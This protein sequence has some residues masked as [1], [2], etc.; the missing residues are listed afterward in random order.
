M[1]RSIAQALAD[2]AAALAAMQAPDGSF[3]FFTRTP[4]LPWVPCD[5]IFATASVLL[6]AAAL[7]PQE[8]VVRAAAY[9]RGRRRPDGLWQYDATLDVPPDADTTACS[10]AA[11]SEC[12]GADGLEEGADLL[13]S[14]WR[15]DGGPFRTWRVG[16]M[17]SQ[18]D[19]DDAVVNCN[20]VCAL[21]RLGSP[22]TPA[23]LEA[24]RG[25]VQQSTGGSRYYCAP[26]TL[27]HALDRAGLD[28][29]ALPP[30]ASARPDARDVL[31]CVEWL[32]G[33]RRPD[34]DLVAGVLAAQERD[35]AWPAWP[36]VTAV[37]RPKP[38]WGSAAVSTALALEALGTADAGLAA[39]RRHWLARLVG[40]LP[41]RVSRASGSS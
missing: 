10:L 2:G 25:L 20:V 36:W 19:R 26:A 39:G 27:A 31:G 29:D 30:A 18:R 24:V 1:P 34:A 40:K 15:P 5:P 4:P 22:A 12:S 9:V 16:G 28:P 23:E 11:L 7:L 13:R 3:P 21:S 17:W 38:F 33:L 32:C 37:G 8:N 35:G 41:S 6:S 14:F